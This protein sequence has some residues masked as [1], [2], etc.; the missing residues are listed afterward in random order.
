MAI[1]WEYSVWQAETVVKVQEQC[2][3]LPVI[4]KIREKVAV[5][6]KEL[7][8]DLKTTRDCSSLCCNPL[9]ETGREG[10][11]VWSHKHPQ[12]ST[13]VGASW[14]R[15]LCRQYWDA[16]YWEPHKCCDI[17]GEF[18]LI[19]HEKEDKQNNDPKHTLS[20]AQ[21]WVNKEVKV[22]AW[23]SLSMLKL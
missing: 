3:Y 19:Y 21:D 11:W 15:T 18:Y 14:Y 22:L 12:W 17:P 6:L 9:P 16:L 10:L 20:T 5:A 8:G 7:Q 4:R 2:S 23:T 13:K 1:G